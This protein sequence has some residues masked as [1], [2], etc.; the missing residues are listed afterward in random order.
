MVKIKY[1]LST[2][3]SLIASP[4]SNLAWYKEL[5]QFSDLKTDNKKLKEHL[6]VIYPFYQYGEYEKWSSS[7]NY[8]LP[9]STVKGA[10]RGNISHDNNLMV[11]DI[12]IPNEFIVLR[13]L[14]KV[15]YL[16]KPGKAELKVFL[17]NVGVEMV[18]AKTDLNGELYIKD[19]GYVQELIKQANHAA[20]NKMKQMSK[21]LSTLC[22]GDY[23]DELKVVLR[24]SMD[25]LES[26]IQDNDVILLGGYKGLLHSLNFNGS[27]PSDVK[28]CGAVYLDPETNLHHGLARLTILS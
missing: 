3:S 11:D 16:E 14:Q 27:L 23:S 26:L 20:N 8:Y 1:R 18:K 12:Q 22:E 9:G 15:Q 4:R 10:I 19:A 6:S 25:G 17:D 28:A 5:D 13:N 2:I 24:K 21:Y 7:A